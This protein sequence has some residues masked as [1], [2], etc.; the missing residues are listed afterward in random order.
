MTCLSLISAGA[1][2]RENTVHAPKQTDYRVT[3]MPRNTLVCLKCFY[4]GQKLSN[5][6]QNAHHDNK[7]QKK[8]QL[9]RDGK[10]VRENITILHQAVTEG[11][12]HILRLQ[13]FRPPPTPLV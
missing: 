8:Q 11:V 3:D 5:H 7:Q 13:I 6:L 4:K 10:Y 12:V 2:N 1:L 9:L